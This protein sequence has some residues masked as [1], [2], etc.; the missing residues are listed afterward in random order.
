[1]DP[2]GVLLIVGIAVIGL[3]VLGGIVAIVIAL[4]R[5]G[6]RSATAAAPPSIGPT[7]ADTSP[8]AAYQVP[9]VESESSSISAAFVVA[10]RP[11]AP[12][13]DSV[14]G[15]SVGEGS[16][17]DASPDDRTGSA[18]GAPLAPTVLAGGEP[19]AGEPGAGEP[20]AAA[21][22]PAWQ[23]IVGSADDP[24]PFGYTTGSFA[25][26]SPLANPWGGASVEPLAVE[27]EPE[28]EP[29]PTPAP[30]PAL[31]P[32]SD[33][34][35]VE[36]ESTVLI[37][38]RGQGPAPWLLILDTGDRIGIEA[39]SVVLGRRPAATEH[40]VP[41]VTVPDPTKTLSKVHARLDLRGEQWTIT[42]LDSTNG[43]AIVEPGGRERLLERGGSEVVRG[44]FVLGEVGLVLVRNPEALRRPGMQ[45][46]PDSLR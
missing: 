34:D 38:G 23:D 3:G 9:S 19:G 36:D 18:D 33:L 44:R 8:F 24:E 11:E 5:R 42:D 26:P 29:E 31:D 39:D 43:T 46:S 13:A 41:G 40:G 2:L 21:P 32:A 16:S 22:I 15:S 35:A 27:P 17:G 12:P 6:H 25:V 45:H 37:A 7:L 28:P 20:A 10:P 14:S 30:A 1:M 4:V